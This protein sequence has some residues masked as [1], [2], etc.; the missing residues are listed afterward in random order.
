MFP[1]SVDYTHIECA[2]H[3][4]CVF[5]TIYMR[6][7]SMKSTRVDI[8]RNLQAWIFHTIYTHKYGFPFKVVPQLVEE[9]D[10]DCICYIYK[11]RCKGR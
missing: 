7:Y 9:L 4:T 10:K 6:G 5:H 3:V 1:R 8:P 2:M 11:H